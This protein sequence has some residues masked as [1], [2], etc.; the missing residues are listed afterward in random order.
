M[1]RPWRADAL[2]TVQ[3]VPVTAFDAA[4]Q[5][6]LEPMRELTRRLYAAGVR[7]FIPC[8]GSAEFHSLSADE[9]VASVRMTRETAG[10]DAIV[11]APVGQQLSFAIE[12]G[13]RSRD[14]GADC[15]LVM[16]LSFPYLSDA[17][18][19]DYLL[20]LLEATASP[21]L[22][23]KKDALP[24]DAL[25]LEMAGQPHVV[26]VKYAVNDLDAF[27]KIVQ[28]DNG[29]IDWFCGSAERF[30]PFFALAGAPGYTSGAGNIC[31]RLTLAMHAA[32]TR[33]DWSEALR[34]Q[35]LIRPIE[36]YRARAGSSYNISFLKH[37][38]TRTGLDFGQPRPPQ[39]RLT[40]AEMQEIDALLEPI[41]A[42]E[43]ELAQGRVL[44]RSV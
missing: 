18:A 11:M 36:D 14:A 8:A 27:Q 33:G 32:L 20:A 25:L 13:Q 41:L 26:G 31:P 10:P 37:A 16:P 6:N 39:R 23:Y 12:V 29:R 9:I 19:R 7:V 44:A 24:S 1:S 4:G 17:G 42:A 30:S 35:K 21:T 43:A 3:L 2:R 40:P 28:Q 5:L 34:F 38:I 22:I 15:L